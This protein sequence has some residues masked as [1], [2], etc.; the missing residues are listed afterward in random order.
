MILPPSY[1]DVTRYFKN[2]NNI[3]PIDGKVY[4]IS[5]SEYKTYQ[6]KQALE[7]IAVLESRAISYEDTA[8]SIRKTIIELKKEAGLIPEDPQ[9]N[10]PA[11]L[12][13]S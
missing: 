3:L 2:F 11:S 1:E 13:A 6:K 5:D 12:D 9:D 7:E 8:A 10:A 4:V